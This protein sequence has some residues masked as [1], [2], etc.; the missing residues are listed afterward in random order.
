MPL[1]LTVIRCVIISDILSVV[2]ETPTR[3]S[4][5]SCFLEIMYMKV[6]LAKP[7]SCSVFEIEET[8]KVNIMFMALH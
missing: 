6:N 4:C 1:C 7:D 8:F 3:S 5:L 2:S